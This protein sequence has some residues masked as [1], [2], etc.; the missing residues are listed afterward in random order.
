MWRVILVGF[1]SGAAAVPLFHEGTNFLIYHNFRWLQALFGV[2]E[3]FRPLSPG[4]SLRLAAPLGFPE[5]LN[6][7]FWGGSWGVLLAATLRLLRAPALLTGFLFGALVCTGFGF[8]PSYGEKGLPFWTVIYL[9]NW[10]RI[11]LVNGA[12]GWGAA[13]LMRTVGLMDRFRS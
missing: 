8:A 2:A 11:A 13:A 12:W 3:G 7:A 5:V 10:L 9:P 4:F 6:L 1:L